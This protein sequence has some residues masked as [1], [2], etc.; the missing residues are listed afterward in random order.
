MT[1]VMSLERGM[2]LDEARE[3]VRADDFGKWD[4]TVPRNDLN[5]RDGLLTFPHEIGEQQLTPSTWATGQLCTR[6]GIPAPYF[7]KCPP[8]LQDSQANHWLR[9][10]EHKPGEKWLLRAKDYKLRAVLSERYSPLDNAV[11]LDELRPILPDNYRVDWFGLADESLH[12][13][14]VDP[15]RYREVLPDD[16]LTVGIHLANSEVGYRSVTVDALVYR[17]VC[18]NGLI[19]LVKGKS[20]MRQRHLHVSEVRFVGALSEAIECALQQSESFL[21]QLKATTKT[22]VPQIE[23]VMEK[24][25]EKWHLSEETQEAA[26]RAL[27]Q[28]PTSQQETL[29]SLTNAYTAAA[30]SLPDEARYDLEILAGNLAEHGVAAYM[31]RRKKHERGGMA[32]VEAQPR[33]GRHNEALLQGDSA[34]PPKESKSIVELAREMFDAEIVGRTP[35]DG[36]PNGNGR[37]A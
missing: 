17:L 28:E 3:S 7:R 1:A 18:A 33:N 36:S 14:V 4:I 12:L 11:L 26:K 34:T 21:E 25:A 9:H 16:A 27:L 8:Q 20:L 35:R 23:Q 10:A 22:P 31:P 2:R 24:I 6:L 32:D 5:L 15:E 29:Y 30:R 19:R 37:R 13:R